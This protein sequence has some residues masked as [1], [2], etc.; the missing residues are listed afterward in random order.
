[1]RQMARGVLFLLLLVG[2]AV[3]ARADVTPVD[4]G[5]SSND[6]K[7]VVNAS[8]CDADICVDL[9]YTGPAVYVSIFNPIIFWANPLPT[10]VPS[11]QTVGCGS[12]VFQCIPW[13]TPLF[14]S[15]P[16]D[17]W[18]VWFFGGWLVPGHTYEVGE[19]NLP[20]LQ[21]TLPSDFTCETCAGPDIVFTPEHMRCSE[22]DCYSSW[23]ECFGAERWACMLLC[24]VSHGFPQQKSKHICQMYPRRRAIKA[25][26]WP[27]TL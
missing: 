11:G 17:F 27:N 5:S 12:D 9:T 19:S 3:A 15:T 10:P 23:A 4:L 18:S 13:T 2:A 6:F 22:P 20:S 26:I 8:P 14:S 16:T 1:M 21:L 24:D 7:V 25:L